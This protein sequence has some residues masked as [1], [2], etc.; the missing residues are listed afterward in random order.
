MRRSSGRS[1]HVG[2]RRGRDVGA[3][4]A[5]LRLQEA[6]SSSEKRKSRSSARS[7]P[8]VF[9]EVAVMP[10]PAQ[11]PPALQPRLIRIDLPRMQ[12]EHRRPPLRP[13]DARDAPA[14]PRSTAGGGS[15]RRRRPAGSTAATRTVEP[16]TSIERAGVALEHGTDAAARPECRSDRGGSGRCSRRSGSLPRSARRAPTAIAA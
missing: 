2:Q 10:E 5:D 12:V 16:G 13:V 14:R 7:R 11:A 4:L 1:P 3:R 9:S 15:S 8:S 6:T